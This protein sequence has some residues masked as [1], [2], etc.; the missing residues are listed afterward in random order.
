[1][2]SINSFFSKYIRQRSESVSFFGQDYKHDW[3]VIIISALIIFIGTVVM[4]GVLYYQI[5]TYDN[6][7]QGDA[8]V[9][10]TSVFKRDQALIT[11]AQEKIE[12]KK[13]EFE[14]VRNNPR[15]YIDPSI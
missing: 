14:N 12:A 3:F 10:V 5:S 6:A 13:K 9:A 8:P 11:K 7:K 1:M 2:K 4:G 15:S